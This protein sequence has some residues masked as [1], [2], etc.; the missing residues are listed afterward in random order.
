[1]HRRLEWNV[2]PLYTF[3]WAERSIDSAV[4]PGTLAGSVTSRFVV[5][6]RVNLQ[7]SRLSEP[8]AVV[9]VGTFPVP[10]IEHDLQMAED[11]VSIHAASSCAVP[12]V[13]TPP[14]HCPFT[15][16]QTPVVPT[17]V[18]TRSVAILSS[19]GLLAGCVVA[20]SLPPTSRLSKHSCAGVLVGQLMHPV[21]PVAS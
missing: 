14:V 19:S 11:D 12:S 3:R 4:N 2:W 20:S 16:V 13:H 6:H 7:S 8:V 10:S 21:V 17:G 1:M 5:M 18:E 9:V 15:H